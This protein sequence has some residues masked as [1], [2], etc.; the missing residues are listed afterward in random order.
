MPQKKGV[1]LPRKPS[2]YNLFIKENFNT[3]KSGGGEEKYSGHQAVKA[4]KDEVSELAKSWG[5]L[6]PEEKQTYNTRAT[7]IKPKVHLRR[8]PFV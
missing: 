8:T 7:L 5:L 6:T 3:T 2:G 4:A 1:G